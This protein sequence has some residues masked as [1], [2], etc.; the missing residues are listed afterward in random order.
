[1]WSRYRLRRQTFIWMALRTYYIDDADVYVMFVH[2]IISLI[3]LS[4]TSLR[5]AVAILGTP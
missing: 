3:D 4:M 2:K 1:M 5:A